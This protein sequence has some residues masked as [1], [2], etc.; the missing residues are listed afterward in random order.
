MNEFLCCSFVMLFSKALIIPFFFYLAHK[1]I[2]YDI[3]ANLFDLTNSN[4]TES[5]QTNIQMANKKTS[6]HINNV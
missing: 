4:S 6:M 5:R 2:L 3:K 1:N